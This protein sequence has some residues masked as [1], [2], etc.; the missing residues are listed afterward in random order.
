G[1]RIARAT[2]RRRSL[3]Q[4]QSTERT[5]GGVV[6]KVVGKAKELAGEATGRE[7]LAREGRLQQAQSDAERDARG[8][9]GDARRREAEAH[10]REEQAET[11]IERRS[12]ENEVAAQQRELRIEQDRHAAEGEATVE[13]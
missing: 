1:R 9:A 10:L 3:T 6:G 7:D 5:A 2:R 12:L 8:S 11:D 4:H 13:S